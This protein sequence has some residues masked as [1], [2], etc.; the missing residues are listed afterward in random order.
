[1][2]RLAQA[3]Q[4]GAGRMPRRETGIDD[5]AGLRDQSSRFGALPER[6]QAVGELDFHCRNG[7][8]VGRVQ[9]VGI[10]GNG[11]PIQRHRFGEASFVCASSNAL[12]S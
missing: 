1:M 6:G 2:Q 9:A 3:V 4:G 11:K 12:P 10:A 7:R 5:C 8:P